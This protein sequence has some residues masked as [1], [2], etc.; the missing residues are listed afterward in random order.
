MVW[1]SLSLT[2]SHTHIS[3]NKETDISLFVVCLWISISL[4][5]APLSYFAPVC[6]SA[7]TLCALGHGLGLHEAFG[8]ATLEGILVSDRNVLGLQQPL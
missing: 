6:Q 2:H 1:R 5:F 3:V 4:L 8:K 7:S